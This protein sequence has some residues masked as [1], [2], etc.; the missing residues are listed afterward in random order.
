MS[1]WRN[2]SGRPLS[3]ISWLEA[4]HRAK[5]AERTAFV[6]SVLKTNPKRIVDLGCG[7]GLWL[8]LFNSEAAPSCEFLGIDVDT[9][10]IE[11]ARTR[12][13]TW[14]RPTAFMQLDIEAASHEI[15]E[16]D[17]FLAFNLFPYL[18]DPTQF[19]NH[20]HRQTRL[21]GVVAVR[22]YD[23]SL[24]RLGPMPHRTRNSVDLSLQAAILGSEQ[25]RHY[26]MD[27]VFVALASS[28]FAA[29]RIDFEL[30]RRV[31][32]YPPEFLEY[33]QNS[34]DWMM[35]YVSDFA[36]PALQEWYEIHAQSG[37]SAPSYFMEVDLV[38]WLS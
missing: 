3:A 22:Q 26:D 6:R 10:A 8:E 28:S 36:R 34:I 21:G 29:R 20:L 7:P 27:R 11:L 37:F 30:F 17:V 23:G 25:F 35:D 32:P 9:A 14:S 38:A 15:P 13:A 24:L 5:L 12:A 19:L 2:A 16:A 18:S 31:S 1:N 33:L 4:H